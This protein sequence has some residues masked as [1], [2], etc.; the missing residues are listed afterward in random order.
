MK[1]TIDATLS[2]KLEELHYEV[3]SRKEVITTMLSNN[4]NNSANTQLFEYYQN[5][6]K[7]YFT[8]YNKTKQEMIKQYNI[9]NT[10]SWSLDF[11]THEVTIN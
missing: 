10:D 2:T 7:K 6:Y 3:M 8:E 4:N 11:A 9:A 5:E 1:I